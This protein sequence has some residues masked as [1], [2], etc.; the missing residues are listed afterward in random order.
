[1]K[2]QPLVG[3]DIGS[4]KI[5]TLI[6]LRS[7]ESNSINVVGVASLPSSGIKKSQ[8]VDIDDVIKSITSSVEA[9]ER[10]AGLSVSK[11]FINIGGS[12]I[13]SKN[14]TGVVAVSEP[15]GEITPE[16][17]R[18]VIDSARAVSLPT[19][20]DVLHVL[21]RQ[22]K[23]DG[24]DG[25]K[26]PVSMTGIRL[27]AEAHLVL[28]STIS[29]K[30][31]TKCVSELGIGV[32]GLVYSG[33]AASESVLTATEKE[34]GVVLVDIGGGTTS[35]AIWVDGSLSHSAVLPIGA[36]NIT[37]DLA[38]GMRLGLDVAEEV[39]KHLGDK[40]QMTGK[41]SKEG[42]NGDD[43]EGD[44]DLAKFGAEEHIKASRKTL[45]EGIIRPRLQEIFSMVG[46]SIKESGF[47]GRTPA[48]VVITGGGAKTVEVDTICKRV[49][50]MPV[51]IGS[52]HSL[53]GLVDDMRHDPAYSVSEGLILY[54][55][56]S[57]SPARVAGGTSI[58][59]GLTDKLPKGMVGRAVEFIKQFLP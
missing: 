51:R 31:L 48:G 6:A 9:A 22:Y 25:I 39:K 13:A 15:E 33:L 29:I 49:L 47:G 58:V 55:T 59:R 52:P 38:I 5:T 40:I 7:E 37:N 12:Q 34:L 21:P 20:Q 32:E 57:N 24:Q 1:M 28:G 45:V 18:R 35:I 16:D 23:V 43:K 36:K 56:K 44:L 27:E 30:N 54:A 26:D 17:V 2:A 42:K 3:I 4:S 46:E 19:S 8:I 53:N 11:A 50:S 10:M 41:E 14:S